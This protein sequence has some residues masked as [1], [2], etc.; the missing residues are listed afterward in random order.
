ML[1]ISLIF[2]F[3]WSLTWST[4]TQDTI[5]DITKNTISSTSI[6]KVDHSDFDQ[7]VNHS[8]YQLINGR[9]P[10]LGMSRIYSLGISL[11]L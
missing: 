5:Q 10:G 4:F 1:R 3:I 8:P 11:K 2:C 7:G 6:G 9:M